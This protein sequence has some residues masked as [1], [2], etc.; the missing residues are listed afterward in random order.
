M[1]APRDFFRGGIT[2][3]NISFGVSSKKKFILTLWPSLPPVKKSQLPVGDDI[4]WISE[5]ARKIISL[6]SDEIVQATSQFT[7]WLPSSFSLTWNVFIKIYSKL[8]VFII[9]GHFVLNY[10]CAN[11]K[12]LNLCRINSNL[13]AVTPVQRPCWKVVELCW[14]RVPQENK[15]RVSESSHFLQKHVFYCA[16]S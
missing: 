6:T 4:G 13:H 11:V 12:K 5:V 9:V 10:A 14:L 16:R 1:K 15:F 7:E 8:D 3:A 2:P